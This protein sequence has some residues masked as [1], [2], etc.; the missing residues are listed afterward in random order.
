M[1]DLSDSTAFDLDDAF[2]DL[3]R[4]VN[5]DVPQHGIQYKESRRMFY[6]GAAAVFFRTLELTALEDDKA[7]EQLANLQKQL[8]EFFKDRVAHE[9]D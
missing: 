2:E 1:N 8:E 3:M 5:P 4:R 9:K 6:A 7:E